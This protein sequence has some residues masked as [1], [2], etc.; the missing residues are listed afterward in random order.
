M[1]RTVSDIKK[2]ARHFVNKWMER[3]KEQQEG[4]S[5]WEDLL[6]KVYGVEDVR[7]ELEFEKPVL[8]NGTWKHID[9]YVKNSKTV[10]EQKSRTVNLDDR[11]LQSDEKELTALEQGIRYFEKLDKPDS[12]RF[13]IACNFKEFLIWDSY[14]K[15]SAP[16]RFPLEQLPDRWRELKFLV[17]PYESQPDFE[18]RTEESVAKTATDY[19]RRLYKSLVGNRKN[20][21]SDEQHSL[22]VFCVRWVFC[23]F[24]EDAGVF[25]NMQLHSFVEKFC[26]EDLKEQ[27][28]NLFEFLDM[29]KRQTQVLRFA[30]KAL[31]AFPYVDGGLFQRDDR[32]AT[33]PIS[34]QTRTL[35]LNAW[36]IYIEETNERFHWNDISPTN[37]GC[38]FEST[39]EKSVRESGGMHY[40]TPDNI[41]RVI[42]PLFLDELEG[43]LKTI[44]DMPYD[45]SKNRH[46]LEQAIKS[47]R[48][49]LSSMRFLDPA[50]G[51]G[52]FLT[53]TYKALHNIELQ[54]IQRELSLT[55]Q[56][57]TGNVDPCNVQISQFF[58]IEIDD[59]A[60]N[61]AKAA[62][63]IAKCQMLQKTEE[64][65]KCSLDI[66]PLPKNANIF[67]CDALT[68]DWD[69]VL[70][71][72]ANAPTFII[73]NPPFQGNKKMTEEQ[74]KSMLAAMPDKIG[75][76]KV[77]EKQG[78][79]DFVCAW[80]AKAAEYM[81]GKKNI[82]AAFVSTNS[83]VQGEQIAPL[84]K[85]L[86]TH[87]KTHILFA[88]KTFRWFN[89]ADE[90][91]HVHCVIIGFYQSP[92][93]RNV[94]HRLFDE[95]H[96]PQ[97]AKNI[98]AYLMDAENLFI[99]NRGKPLCEVPEMGIGNKPIDDGNYLFTKEEMQMF[100][101]K[102]PEAE[103]YFRPW[104]GADEFINRHPRFCL[105][106]GDCTPAQINL[107]PLCKKRVQA[108][109]DFRKKSKSEQTR[110]LAKTPRRFHV[111]NMP[112]STYLL[113][114]R[115]SSEN[116]SYVPMGFLEPDNL[117]SDAI[118]IVPN[119]A[120]YHFGVLESRLHMAWMRIVCGRLKSDYRYSAGIVYNNFPWPSLT[121]EQKEEIGKT[122]ENILKVRTDFPD[123][124]L[125][126]LYDPISMP[127]ELLKA[128]ANNDKAV[129]KAFGIDLRMSDEAIALE[130]MRR[131]VKL[132]TMMPKKK[133]RAMKR[134]K[135]K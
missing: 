18:R 117:S 36:N 43:E 123:S 1:Q 108:V 106:L 119:I 58:G 14:H 29:E 8:F 99:E 59:F 134:N 3:G 31:L 114:P 67:Q 9:I 82:A 113:V 45:T 122:A 21:S 4:R 109:I 33:P 100:V 13:V 62:L 51:S 38:I 101:S 79:L 103:Q 65:L 68:V 28:D 22:N 135:N 98:N 63:W 11:G 41:R 95:D 102:E 89:K 10:I 112:N 53:E 80:Y 107:L 94:P 76:R 15:N 128:H 93:K 132:A 6:E 97:L 2:A 73:G 44:L 30:P 26:A 121:E 72:T 48:L 71:R 77:W 125:A 131:S 32:Y 90:M 96:E 57:Y 7:D 42:G 19:V 133:K 130:L 37:F 105:W 115:V 50:C 111:E 24:A 52:N 66:L 54:V 92:R 40:T 56:T 78:S 5:F 88:W 70:K 91:A 46:V 87:Y 81:K 35:L 16:I 127:A 27:F 69:V 60:A 34:E 85:P 83:I 64:V 12:G 23:L 47:F 86:M 20:L 17:E 84:W 120:S 129:A 49:K 124:S 75:N 118:Q 110:E 104:Y 61:V 126:D 39:V 25:D 55:F 74:K 116:R